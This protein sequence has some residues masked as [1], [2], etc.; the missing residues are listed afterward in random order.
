MTIV[1]YKQGTKDYIGNIKF[2]NDMCIISIFYAN[3]FNQLTRIWKSY[4]DTTVGNLETDTT[5]MSVC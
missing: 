4:I 2:R 1:L 5:Y 3:K